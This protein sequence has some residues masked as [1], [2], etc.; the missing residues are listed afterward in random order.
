MDFSTILGA[1]VPLL[2]FNPVTK[3][4]SFHSLVLCFSLCGHLG[5]RLRT[6]DPQP[7][8]CCLTTFDPQPRYVPSLPALRV[9]L[10]PKVTATATYH[11]HSLGLQEL[12]W[13]HHREVGNIHEDV[14]HS[15]Q[16]NTNDNG[17]GQV[18]ERDKGTGAQS[19][20]R[21]SCEGAEMD[22]SF[23]S[24]SPASALC[25]TGVPDALL[26]A[27]RLGILG[28]VAPAKTRLISPRLE[29]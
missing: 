26:G 21:A 17:H 14:A 9:S 13:S 3:T 2:C 4:T 5:G 24:V 22:I 29:N 15:H 11:S 16:R 8:A 28:K 19:H 6:R 10:L 1:L 20:P 27:T 25:C 23:L 12:C 18:S 7:T